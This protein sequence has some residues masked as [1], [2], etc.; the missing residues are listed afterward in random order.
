MLIFTPADEYHHY[1]IPFAKFRPAEPL[2]ANDLL[3]NFPVTRLLTFLF[4][5]K[6]ISY[7]NGTR[8]T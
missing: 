1:H 3:P 5:Y 8:C 7:A 6:I 4:T 2:T